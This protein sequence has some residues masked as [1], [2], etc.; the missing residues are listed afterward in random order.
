MWERDRQAWERK[1]KQR[2]VRKWKMV[3]VWDYMVSKIAWWAIMMIARPG[4][5]TS[6]PA[7]FWGKNEC[8]CRSFWKDVLSA[9]WRED[10]R[11]GER[12][13]CFLSISMYTI[14]R[15]FVGQD[16]KR[17]PILLPFVLKLDDTTSNL[18]MFK[19]SQGSI[20][21][22]AFYGSIYLFFPWCM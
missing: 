8:G 9:G 17:W 20:A 1:N 5:N 3:C 15:V 10:C 4:S 11:E 18:K 7:D 13:G 21:K 16:L 2:G 19:N 22:W 6:R 12:G 14:V